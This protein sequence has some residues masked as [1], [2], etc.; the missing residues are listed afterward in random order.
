MKVKLHINALSLI[1]STYSCHFVWYLIMMI[2][3]FKCC[4]KLIS[5]CDFYMKWIYFSIIIWIMIVTSMNGVIQNLTIENG[6]IIFYLLKRWI[7]YSESRISNDKTSWFAEDALVK[8]EATKMI[9]TTKHTEMQWFH[10][11]NVG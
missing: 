5:N 9:D 6:M 8:L 3:N 4:I 1:R 10:C 11:R 2:N 7:I